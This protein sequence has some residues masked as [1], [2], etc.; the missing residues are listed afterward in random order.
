MKK[1]EKAITSSNT[2]VLLAV[3]FSGEAVIDTLGPNK[4]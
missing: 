2:L 3:T 1:Q 4:L